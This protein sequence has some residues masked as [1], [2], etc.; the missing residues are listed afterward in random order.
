MSFARNFAAGQQIA[1][2]AMDTFNTARRNRDLRRIA[3]AR[4]EEISGFSEADADQIRAMSQA[5]NPETGQPYYQ[6]E[7]NGQ[8]GLNV[9]NNFSYEGAD[10]QMVAPGS[11]LGLQ[12]RPL[13]EFLGR[14]YE[15]PLSDD[16]M[17]A[18]RYRA[19]ADVMGREDPMLGMRMRRELRQDERDGWRFGVEQQRAPLQTRQLEQS[20]LTG[21]IQL[22]Q[23]QRGLNVQ[24]AEDAAMTMPADEVRS[25]LTGYLNTNR[26][27][28]PL[29]VL[30]QTKDGFI[31]ADRN[32]QTGEVGPQ[33]TVPLSVGR[34][35][36]V[37]M[38]LAEQGFGREALQ[39]LSG[40]DENIT[41]LV[42][43]YN[44]INM[45]NA[46]LTNDALGHQFRLDTD[47]ERLGL[48]AR[49]T[50]ARITALNNAEAR[51]AAEDWSIIGS[52]EDGRGL[53]RFNRR[54]GQIEVVPLPEGT[55]ARGLFRRI[56]GQGPDISVE[57]IYEQLVGTQ[58][59]GQ[60]RGAMYTPEQALA[61]ARRLA[62]G[63]QDPFM[64][65]LDA[66]LGSGTDP[67]APQ[68]P[69]RPGSTPAPT[70]QAAAPSPAPSPRP[71]PR[72]DPN[73]PDPNRNP[74]TG[75]ARETATQGP[76]IVEAVGRGLDSGAV[77]YLRGKI[78]RGE[79]LTPAET[80][81]AR[82]YNLVP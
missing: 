76:N 61:E 75:A 21:G 77:R 8:G 78:D 70:R 22:G 63:Q 28:I 13:T 57:K 4:P 40:V 59:P 26:S 11:T 73:R 71:Q 60:P 10:G 20:V 2:N 1:Q 52:S 5:I 44:R 18:A 50:S 82:R 47:R 64:E 80:E 3:D 24:R 36:V 58:I 67:F 25:T 65:R 33:F 6:F 43:R 45:D 53:T 46:R 72:P 54:S 48:Q 9:R 23:A 69:T 74:V 15:A 62:A 14:R 30:G 35:L 51:A 29:L 68:A 49:E 12:Q 38:Q 7:D 55:D 66:L 79:P 17:E 39:Y 27:D 42:D 19:M 37:G 31:M 16:Q 32:P 56:S 81:R 34:K 41:A